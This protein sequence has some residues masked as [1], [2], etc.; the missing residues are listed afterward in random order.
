MTTWSIWTYIHVVVC[1]VVQWC[2]C[3]WCVQQHLTGFT[4]CARLEREA[5]RPREG[6]PCSARRRRA[7]DPHEA[8]ETWRISH[9]V[10]LVWHLVG[11]NDWNDLELVEPCWIKNH[12]IVEMISSKLFSCSW[13][14]QNLVSIGV[15][16]H[17]L[18][19]NS[20]L[21]IVYGPVCCIATAMVTNDIRTIILVTI[22]ITTITIITMI[23]TIQ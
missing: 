19:H 6:Q 11:W 12:I 4:P 9:L 10:W 5:S 1:T 18:T 2:W 17:H 8:T 20:S 7:G 16:W 3:C 13:N 14:L 22:P 23:I 15:P 21:S